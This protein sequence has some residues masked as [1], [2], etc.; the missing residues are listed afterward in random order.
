MTGDGAIWEETGG[1]IV[2]AFREGMVHEFAV[3]VSFPF[4]L[5][6]LNGCQ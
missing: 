3:L 6:L 5:P 2:L 4:L 1:T